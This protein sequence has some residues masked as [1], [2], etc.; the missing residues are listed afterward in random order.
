MR[1]T[2][3]RNATAPDA[4][5]AHITDSRVCIFKF[6][7]FF[8]NLFISCLWRV[9]NGVDE[10]QADDQSDLHSLAGRVESKSHL[11]ELPHRREHRE[12]VKSLE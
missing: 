12:R 6:L 5:R 10:E 3:M 9:R 11:R 4:D 2:L 1:R 8:V 7:S